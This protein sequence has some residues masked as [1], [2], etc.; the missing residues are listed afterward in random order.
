MARQVAASLS[1]GDDRA[2]RKST[3]PGQ[4]TPSP[5]ASSCDGCSVDS[6]TTARYAVSASGDDGVVIESFQTPCLVEWRNPTI[7]GRRSRAGGRP[8]SGTSAHRPGRASR[9]HPGNHAPGSAWPPSGSCPC[10]LPRASAT[11]PWQGRRNV[12]RRPEDAQRECTMRHPRT[13]VRH[14]SSPRRPHSS[15]RSMS[16]AVRGGCQGL[17]GRVRTERYPPSSMTHSPLSDSPSSSV[18]TDNSVRSAA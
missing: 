4:P 7:S 15:P 13:A 16:P 6:A 14:R 2:T 9:R 10:Q 8:I 1:S 12:R 18:L 5:N 3:R 11:A 17:R